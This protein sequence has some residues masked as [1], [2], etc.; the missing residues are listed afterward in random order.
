MKKN[1]Y[2]IAHLALLIVYAAFM[3]GLGAYYVRHSS[4]TEIF[5]E[6]AENALISVLFLSL[7]YI[8]IKALVYIMLIAG[9][10]LLLSG[11][12]TALMLVFKKNLYKIN[13]IL[14]ANAFSGISLVCAIGMILFFILV[15][16]I[17][18]ALGYSDLL[19]YLSV[20]TVLGTVWQIINFK[21][22]KEWRIF[23]CE[24][25]STIPVGNKNE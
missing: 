19:I 9:A 7:P 15:L 3:T 1:R 20:L 21:A 8:F 5:G 16:F 24:Y 14:K 17:Y 6:V 12:A 23:F 2:L 25:I 13:A 11:I 10:M 22:M 4:L 18:D